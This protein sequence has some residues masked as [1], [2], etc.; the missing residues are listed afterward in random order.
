MALLVP[1]AG[2]VVDYDPY[3]VMA[4]FWLVSVGLTVASYRVH[5]SEWA[6]YAMFVQAFAVV[7]VAAIG[8]AFVV[9]GDP[10]N[11]DRFFPFTTMLLTN[12]LIGF[13]EFVA[14]RDVARRW[15]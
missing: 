14:A 1:S 9:L 5:D 15:P 3:V 11:G 12:I 8:P 4:T 13:L 6:F 7:A 2:S 10:V